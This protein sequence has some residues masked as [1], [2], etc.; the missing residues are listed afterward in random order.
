MNKEHLPNG[1]YIW[2]DTHCTFGI[3]A[4]LLSHFAA[5]KSCER[6]CDLG[7]GCGILPLLFQTKEGGPVVDAVECEPYAVELMRRSVRENGLQERIMV[8]EQSW[9]DLDLPA[10][11]YDR[12]VCNPPYFAKGGGKESPAAARRLARH[13]NGDT[14]REVTAAAARLLKNKGRFVLCHRPERL[15]DVM[16]TLREHGLEPKRLQWVHDR[17]EKEPFLF[18]CEAIKGGKPSLA[19]LPSLGVKE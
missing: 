6:V 4:V 1:F 13:E 18:L 14:L 17:P 7:T 8:H 10:S 3:D 2:V 11:T 5:P 15:V 12:V 9:C 16:V 19:V